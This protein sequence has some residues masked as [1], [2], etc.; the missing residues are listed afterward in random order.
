MI[1]NL[2]KKQR[3]DDTKLLLVIIIA[4]LIVVWLCTPPGNKFAQVC[5]WGNQTQYLIAKMQNKDETTAYKFLRNNAVYHVRMDQK[6]EALENIDNAITALP[7]YMPET[8][9][10]SLYRDRGMIRLYY[11][12]YKGALADFTRIKNYEFNDY[13]KLAMLYKTNGNNKLAIS[14]CNEIMAKDSSAY[15]AYLCYAD[16]YAGIGRPDAAVNVF[17][18]LID[19]SPS[20]AKYYAD[21][22]QYKLLAGDQKGHDEDMAKAEEL[23]PSMNFNSSLVKDTL[24]P[25][26]LVLGI[27]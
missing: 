17:N 7:V 2:K 8:V 21:R 3:K 27:L 18:L 1:E 15:V 26:T 24:E 25:K 9:L 23:A 22:A 16:I 20:R 12:D 4:F 11:R 14:A 13:F 10:D 6:K 19:K 5:L